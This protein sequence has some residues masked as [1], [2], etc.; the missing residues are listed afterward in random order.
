MVASKLLL[1]AMLPTKDRATA[2]LGRLP[3]ITQVCQVRLKMSGKH[4]IGACP[5]LASTLLT[6]LTGLAKLGFCPA[7]AHWLER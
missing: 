3:A 6:A 2:K 4:C 5:A 7:A 1:V